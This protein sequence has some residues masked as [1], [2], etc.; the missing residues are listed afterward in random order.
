MRCRACD[1]NLSDRESTRKSFPSGTYLDLCD[2]CFE[3][4]KDQIQ[5]VEK[6][7]ELQEDVDEKLAKKFL[8]RYEYERIFPS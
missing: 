4:I 6:D 3:T 7:E 1:K 8:E 5:V 2:R